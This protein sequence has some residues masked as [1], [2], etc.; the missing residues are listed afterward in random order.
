MKVTASNKYTGERIYEVEVNICTSDCSED[1][2]R[3]ARVGESWAYINEIPIAL[4]FEEANPCFIDAIAEGRA[5]ALMNDGK[6]YDIGDYVVYINAGRHELGRVASYGRIENDTIFVCFHKGCTA[7]ATK[8]KE[9]RPATNEE[10]S[11]AIR[12][13][14]VFGH[15]RFEE[16][17]PDYTPEACY[18]YCPDKDGQEVR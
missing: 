4:S 7:S 12:D 15:H 14:L 5:K 9:L 8:W 3:A 2:V 18:M 16:Y 17:C 13:G 11:K 10:I 6:P 1:I